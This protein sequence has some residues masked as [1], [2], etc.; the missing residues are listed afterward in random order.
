MS[1]LVSDRDR[2][3]RGGRVVQGH[4][5]APVRDPERRLVSQGRREGVPVCVGVT[6]SHW[7]DWGFSRGTDGGEPKSFVERSTSNLGL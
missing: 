3:V 6:R 4:Q 7:T 5:P 2:D 1:V